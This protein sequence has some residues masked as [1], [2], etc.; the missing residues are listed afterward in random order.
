MIA[1][2]S[3]RNRGPHGRCWLSLHIVSKI[4]GVGE[5]QD[6][7]TIRL[8]RPSCLIVDHKQIVS[9][10]VDPVESKIEVHQ[11]LDAIVLHRGAG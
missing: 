11:I 6:N 10:L 8:A 7:S 9:W 5:F 1:D 2:S 4:K 3:T